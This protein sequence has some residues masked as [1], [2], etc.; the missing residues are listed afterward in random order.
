MLRSD[1]LINTCQLTSMIK[2]FLLQKDFDQGKTNK[3]IT[4][5]PPMNPDLSGARG[6]KQIKINT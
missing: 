1:F 3:T 4:I 6:K 2:V 5:Q